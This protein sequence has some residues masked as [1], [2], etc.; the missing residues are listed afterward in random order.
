MFYQILAYVLI[1]SFVNM[2]LGSE[3]YS[4]NKNS[5]NKISLKPT[6]RTNLSKKYI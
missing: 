2:K 3:N 1:F 5:N 4:N 6:M